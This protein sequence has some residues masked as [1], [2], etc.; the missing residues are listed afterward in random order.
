MDSSSILDVISIAAIFIY[1]IKGYSRGFAQEVFGLVGVIGGFILAFKYG[2][3]MGDMI[4][5][6]ILHL[7]NTAVLPLIGS[8]LILIGTWLLTRI[9]GM[10]ISSF[11]NSHG[12]GIINKLL[13]FLMGAA[14]VVFVFSLLVHLVLSVPLINTTVDNALKGGI[15]YPYF[16]TISSTL[17]KATPKEF[18]EKT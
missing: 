4:N 18:V 17:I 15:M 1:G 6:S 11:F 10:T 7:Q 16:K 14:K 13:G 2:S 12:L 8:I 3:I 5:N 9:I